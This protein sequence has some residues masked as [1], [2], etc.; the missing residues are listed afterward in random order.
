MGGW[1]VGGGGA[2]LGMA[3]IKGLNMRKV[4]RSCVCH[5][6]GIKRKTTNAHACDLGH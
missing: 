4:F 3:C 6:F 1:G 5:S 2:S